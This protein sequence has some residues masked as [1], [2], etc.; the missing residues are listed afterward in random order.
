VQD[1]TSRALANVGASWS[2]LAR[3][4]SFASCRHG[5]FAWGGQAPRPPVPIACD[6]KKCGADH[7][8]NQ[9]RVNKHGHRQRKSDHLDY[10]EIS[11][12]ECREY[13]DHDRGGAGN[14]AG[15]SGQPLRNC[16]GFTE[17][18]PSGFEDPCDQKHL[19]IHAQSKGDGKGDDRNQGK[20]AARSPM[21]SQ[22]AASVSVLEN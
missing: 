9:C 6:P 14:Q 8:S 2:V 22:E 12:G 1:V 4:A 11:E 15:G 18:T 20:H 7:N 10:Q 19:I 3:Q 13:H 5:C 21:N 16:V 17:P